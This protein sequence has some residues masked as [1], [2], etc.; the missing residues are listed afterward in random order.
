[1]TEFEE[2]SPNFK[3]A[4]LTKVKNNTP[5]WSLI[6]MDLVDVK[7]GWAKVRLPYDKKLDHAYGSAH[8]A[9]VFAPAD[10]AVAMA[11]QGLVEKDEVFTTVEMKINY[12]RP[13]SKGEIIAEAA[14]THKG[15][16]LAIGEVDVRDSQG[17]LVAKALATYMIMK[18][19]R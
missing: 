7:K 19:E 1:M 14:I 12:I 4:M 16:N 15:G 11:L 13:F 17:R 8:G 18:R 6:N 3:K 9:A 10:S 2:L 5:F